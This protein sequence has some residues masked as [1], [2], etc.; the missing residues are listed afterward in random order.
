MNNLL[1][2]I[3][4]IALFFHSQLCHFEA[5]LAR[6]RSF[7]LFIK[8][9]PNIWYSFLKH[10]DLV[11]ILWSL[12]I[13]EFLPV[14]PVVFVD[15]ARPWI[16]VKAIQFLSRWYLCLKLLRQMLLS[17]FQQWLLY[18]QLSLYHFVVNLI[19]SIHYYCYL[20]LTAF[21]ELHL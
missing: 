9:T 20:F 21:W 18:W 6:Y 7:L 10:F 4:L 2:E 15:L 13:W 12:Y 5:W 17:S 11:V 3:I 14:P 1:I 16:L 19:Y 8:L